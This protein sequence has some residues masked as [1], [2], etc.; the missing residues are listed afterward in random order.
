MPAGL[1]LSTSMPRAFARATPARAKAAL[2][3]PSSPIAAKM[4]GSTFRFLR[5]T[6]GFYG[7]HLRRADEKPLCTDIRS[8]C[9]PRWSY[10]LPKT[11]P[12][13]HAFK[14]PTHSH[15]PVLPPGAGTRGRR[16]TAL[17][18]S[19]PD[20][21]RDRSAPPTLRR[22]GSSPASSTPPPPSSPQSSPW[23]EPT[24]APAGGGTVPYL[25]RT[26][27]RIGRPP[28]GR[29]RARAGCARGGWVARPMVCGPQRT[30]Q[31][32]GVRM[33]GRSPCHGGCDLAIA[34]A[35]TATWPSHRQNPQP[36]ACAEDAP[37]LWP[38]R[39]AVGYGARPRR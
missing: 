5:T 14:A 16:P 38:S 27:A 32:T 1:G 18:R 37:S 7:F 4:S 26:V 23:M 2:A 29:G 17:P 12:S 31:R 28:Q 10:P 13:S 19:G 39:L 9:M 20:L 11:S 34:L 33:E 22:R 3:A 15:P 8:E 24:R 25:L 36:A 30:G 21:V 35:A 6:A